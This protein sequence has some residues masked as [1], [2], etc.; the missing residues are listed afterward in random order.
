MNGLTNISIS[1][2]DQNNNPIPSPLPNPFLAGSQTLK[3][4]VANTTP[5]VCSLDT[6]LQFTVDDLPEA[7]PISASLTTVCDDKT[8]P[9]FQDG[10]YAFDTSSFQTAI[11]GG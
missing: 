7:F 11:L 3:V 5:T 4:V 8:D 6:T 1:Y 10:K 2:F 9:V